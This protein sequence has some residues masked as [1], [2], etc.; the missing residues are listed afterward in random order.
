MPDPWP[1][2]WIKL[3][4]H[5][6]QDPDDPDAF[7]HVAPNALAVLLTDAK[8][9][10]ELPPRARTVEV[11]NIVTVHEIVKLAGTARQ[12]IPRSTLQRWRDRHG[13][14]EPLKTVGRRTELWDVVEVREWL[15][16]YRA[17]REEN[18]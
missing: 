3:C 5:H 16:A 18:Q 7:S 11:R 13:F 8:A 2:W 12:P 15:K 1:R 14:P 4:Q 10:Y 17:K 9:K 6:G